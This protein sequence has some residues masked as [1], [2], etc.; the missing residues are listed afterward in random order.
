MCNSFSY[1]QNSPEVAKAAVPPTLHPDSK[2][3]GIIWNRHKKSAG[4]THF[5]LS[6]AVIATARNEAG[7]KP[8]ILSPDCFLRRNDG[9]RRSVLQ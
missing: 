7:S 1:V 2:N 5:N 6:C 4:R 9:A 3:N 8:D